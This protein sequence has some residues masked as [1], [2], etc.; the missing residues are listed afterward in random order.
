MKGE[1]RLFQL[2][3]REGFHEVTM[4][5]RH[6]QREGLNLLKICCKVH[7]AK[8][9]ASTRPQEQGC[10]CCVQVT[11]KRP[12]LLY[13]HRYILSESSGEP[14]ET[15]VGE[16]PG[17]NQEEPQ[18]KMR[19]LELILGVKGSHLAVYEERRQVLIHIV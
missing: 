19:R 13:T 16:T 10:V 14:W 5:Q 1:A 9:P 3:M 18:V 11:A 12:V 4:K 8:G 2:V 17:P 15:E 7:Q 6:R